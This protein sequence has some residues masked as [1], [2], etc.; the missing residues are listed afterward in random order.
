ISPT[1]EASRQPVSRLASRVEPG[2][3]ASRRPPHLSASVRTPSSPYVLLSVRARKAKGSRSVRREPLDQDTD[4]PRERAGLRHA[5]DEPPCGPERDRTFDVHVHLRLIRTVVR[6]FVL[7][8]SADVLIEEIRDEVPL[9]V[10]DPHLRA[11]GRFGE[12]PL[13]EV[14]PQLCLLRR[15]DT[16]TR[17]LK[18]A[19]NLPRPAPARIG[20][21]VLVELVEADGRSA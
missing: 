13:H 12:A 6:A 14:E 3:T 4:E 5:F 7:D 15:A 11:Y 9:E 17:S 1:R 10:L 19:A 18:C 16:G 20:L 2:R 8:R 21:Q